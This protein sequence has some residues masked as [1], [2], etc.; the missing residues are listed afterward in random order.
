V[1]RGTWRTYGPEV[2]VLYDVEAWS[3]P[4]LF[5]VVRAEPQAD[6]SA[7]EQSFRSPFDQGIPP[8]NPGNRRSRALYLGVSMWMAQHQ[9][10]SVA[11]QFPRIGQWVAE[12]T[13]SPD[14]GVNYALTSMPGHM[15][16]WGDAGE[17]SCPCSS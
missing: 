16:V 10:E 6:W 2:L 9:A 13:L 5:R 4:T 3:K 7:F 15:T 17:L 1:A 11:R 8:T 14:A 12:L